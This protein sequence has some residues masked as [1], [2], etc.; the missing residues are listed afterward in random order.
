[1][2]DL[3]LNSNVSCRNSV[4]HSR[5]SEL[6]PPCTTVYYLY[7]IH[8]V[9]CDKRYCLYRVRQ[10]NSPTRHTVNEEQL[11]NESWDVCD[12]PKCHTRAAAEKTTWF[13]SLG[14]L[15]QAVCLVD[16]RNRI[17]AAY[18]ICDPPTDRLT[19]CMVAE[20]T[21]YDQETKTLTTVR[22]RILYRT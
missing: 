3:K 2:N 17:I 13:K 11:S 1:M 21:V 19:A 10:I 5:L 15:R 4:R 16:E 22:D 8:N 9:N 7:S 20:C 6:L 18:I 14:G 12:R